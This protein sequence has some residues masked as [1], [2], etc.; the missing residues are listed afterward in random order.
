[1]A[2]G[3]VARRSGLA[4]SLSPN[5]HLISSPSKAAAPG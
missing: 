1:L 4:F 5:L 2:L 3:A